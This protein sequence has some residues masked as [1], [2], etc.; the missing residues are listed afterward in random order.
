MVGAMDYFDYESAARE[1]KLSAEQ[2]QLICDIVHRDYPHD[3][4]LFELH[5]LRACNAIR[6]GRV[7]LE[8]VVGRVDYHQFL[9]LLAARV[10]RAHALQR[11]ELV[12]FAMDEELRFRADPDGLE[13]VPRQWRRD[14]EERRDA[15]VAGAGHQRNPGAEREPAAP[16][17][18]RWIPHFTALTHRPGPPG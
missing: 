4:M 14:A 17:P 10:K 1:A 13:V 18:V 8:Q 12:E 5:V 2:L 9:R 6:D 3:R 11:T 16:E 7:T 15:W